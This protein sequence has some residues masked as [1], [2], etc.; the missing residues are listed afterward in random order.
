MFP[1]IGFLAQHILG[2]VGSQIKI[3]WI[4][5]LVGILI[6]IKRCHLQTKNL[7]KLIFF[8]KN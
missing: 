2:I 4:F 8:N 3:G 5:S 1:T 7:K 6:N